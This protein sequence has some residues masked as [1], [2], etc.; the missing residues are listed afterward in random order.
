[1]DKEYDLLVIGAGSGGIAA[2][3]RAAGYGRRCAVFESNRIGGTCVN[4]GCVPKK[5][6]WYG[7]QI[8]Q[9][10]EDA[11][12]YGFK[13]KDSSFDWPALVANRQAYIERLHG[14]YGRA[15]ERNGVDCIKA[16]ARFVDQRVLEADGRRYR[17]EH[18]L[19]ATGGHP[20]VPDESAVPGADLG[21]T[22]DGFFKLKR[23]PASM[24][25][26]GAGYVAVEVAGMLAALG[27]EVTL[28]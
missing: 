18:I 19:I 4:V 5:V 28:I 22:S 1:M 8:A 16:E 9:A 25:I 24:I 7:A 26:I 20:I 6:M 2:A 15:F 14:A 21:I 27:T 3:N 10:L 12:D 23:Q 11:P 13:I 17:A